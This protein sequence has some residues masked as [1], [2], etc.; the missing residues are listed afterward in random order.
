MQAER[1]K[2]R[3]FQVKANG[4]AVINPDPVKMVP[5]LDI[6]MGGLGIYLDDGARWPGTSAKLEIMVADCSFYLE[7]LPFQIVN[8]VRAFPNNAS[9]LMD[10]HRYG[11]KFGNLRPAQKAHLKYFMRN[12]TEKST[13]SNFLQGI[14]KFLHPI[15]TKKY[16]GQSC[17]TKIWQ[18]LHRSSL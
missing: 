1:R 10:G 6:S 16:S 15:W 7:K 9:N 17:N 12:Y 11:I 13:I 18:G 2:N 5:I 14:N 4:F 3:R 8:N